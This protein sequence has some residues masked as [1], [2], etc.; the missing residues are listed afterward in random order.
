MLAMPSNTMPMLDNFYDDL[1]LMADASFSQPLPTFD[2]LSTITY[3]GSTSGSISSS[4]PA[5]LPAYSPTDFSAD[6]G[7]LSDLEL[8][9]FTFPDTGNFDIPLLK[10]FKVGMTIAGLLNCADIMWDPTFKRTITAAQLSDPALLPTNLLPTP[11]QGKIPHHP[12]LDVLPWPSVRTK[13]IAVF[14]QPIHL[15]PP[16]ARDETAVMRLV[17]DLDDEA[18][19]VRV[20]NDPGDDTDALSER[21]W[22]IGQVFY[23]N[24]WWALDAGLI[25]RSNKLRRDRG[26]RPLTLMP[27]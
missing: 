7:E 13:L 2:L 18:D 8:S 17:Q 22:E 11:I 21:S 3:D 19:G 25:E 10:L 16:I 27:E 24:W 5:S 14:S 26:A 9:Q 20:A 6:L 15:R 12:I 4:L 1:S 23:R